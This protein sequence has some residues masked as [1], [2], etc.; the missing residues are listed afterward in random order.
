[1]DGCAALIDIFV[2]RGQDDVRVVQAFTVDVIQCD[3]CVAQRGGTHAVFQDISCK[4]GA[5]GAHKRNF[6]HNDSPFFFFSVV[7]LMKKVYNETG[8]QDRKFVS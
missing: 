8:K 3:L 2:D 1:M 4:Y 6:Y 5:A 7:L